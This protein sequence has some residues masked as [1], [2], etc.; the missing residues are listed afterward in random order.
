M[1]GEGPY[2]IQTVSELTGVPT[3]TLRAW[4]RRY[5]IPS[6]SR[7]SAAYRLYD[8]EDIK[9]IQQLRDLCEQGM[10]PAEAAKILQA[11]SNTQ[12]TLPLHG[13]DP[14]QVAQENILQAIYDFDSPKLDYAIRKAMFL[15][16][17]IDV[18]EHVFTP[19]MQTVGEQWHAGKLSI[20]QEHF[21]TQALETTVREMLRLM[22][23]EASTKPA[24]VGC[25]ADEEHMFPAYGV[26]F[27]L[28]QRHLRPILL[29]A[30]TPPEALAE[31]VKNLAP[32]LVALSVTIAPPAKR[33]QLLVSEYAKACSNVPWIVGGLASEQ[34]RPLI[35]QHGGIVYHL[36]ELRKS[37]ALQVIQ[38]IHLE[39]PRKKAP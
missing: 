32:S 1:Q 8:A 37:N 17:A 23:L 2:R 7:S 27:L 28:I 9:I 14:Y 5:G 24:I 21:A 34:L 6:P 10:S 15:S 4:E 3:A 33:A 11:Q 19:V 29:G 38:T 30:R 35:E 16:S 18:Y 22:S 31:A 36:D 13:H 39:S 12:S 20:A 25:F 26:A